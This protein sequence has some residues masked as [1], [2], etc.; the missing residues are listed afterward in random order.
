PRTNM[1]TYRTL[2]N[3]LAMVFVNSYDRSTRVYQAMRLRGFSG[4]FVSV[5]HFQ[6]NHADLLTLVLWI[7][8]V[9][10]ILIMDLF[11]EFMRV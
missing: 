4:Q 3:L 11:W 9:L 2:G 8:L 7:S 10:V 1:H 5:R 6:A